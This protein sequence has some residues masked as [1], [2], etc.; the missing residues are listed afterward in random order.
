MPW[1]ENLTT[2]R[3]ILWSNQ[4]LIEKNYTNGQLQFS[5]QRAFRLMDQFRNFSIE[6]AD[7][8]ALQQMLS[9][10]CKNSSE[11]DFSTLR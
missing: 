1:K 8:T 2:L 5:K 7:I 9:D 10:A 3:N 6:N 11:D 4:Y